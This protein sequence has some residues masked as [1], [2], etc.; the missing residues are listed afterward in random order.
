VV[1]AW[2]E[3]DATATDGLLQINQ[4][5]SQRNDTLKK[6]TSSCAT[7]VAPY[8]SAIAIKLGWQMIQKIGRA[9]TME[10]AEQFQFIREYRL[11]AES[12]LVRVIIAWVTS[13][14]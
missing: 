3:E 10:N 7:Y 2:C 11:K 9:E 1:P 8:V 5:N 14:E 6:L 13:N 4:L 12:T